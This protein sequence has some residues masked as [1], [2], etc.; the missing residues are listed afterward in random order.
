MAS[1]KRKSRNGLLLFILGPT[2]GFALYLTLFAQPTYETEAKLIVRESQGGGGGA[3]PG[4]AATLLGFGGRTSM[5]DVL[6]L[7]QYLHSA[8]FIEAAAAKFSLRDHFHSSPLDPF[9]R[10]E[11][12]AEAETF[13]K[14]FR[15]MVTV[16]IRAD[17][18]VLTVQVRAF[19]PQ[20]AQD[21]ARFI[22]ERSEET[23]NAL[24]QRMIAAQ[25]TLAQAELAKK[26]D[27]LKEVRAQLLEFQISHAMVDPVSETTVYF[28]NVAA[29][30]GRLMEKRTELRAKSHYLQEDAFELRRLR[31]EI[32]ALEEQR[33][34]ETRLLVSGGDA[35][36]ARTLQSYEG[37][38]LQ[39][40]FA[41][42]A[43]TAAVATAEQAT[44]EAT[45]QEK[46]LL[47]IA[48]PHAPEK[49]VFPR[50]LRGTATVLVLSCLG[51][52]ILRLIVATVRDHSI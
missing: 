47:V 31:Q 48:P 34:E 25:T 29:L 15:K 52:G 30:D 13:Y 14:F 37:L 50:P 17:S 18:G 33:T 26:L 44:M 28:G 43:Y 41:L 19:S 23:I 3:L 9:R 46:F 32:R 22:I 38:K 27:R 40:E 20:T 6:I 24:N 45:R 8:E 16:G 39:L 2:A 36:M 12:G 11:A 21:L 1:F 51:Y 49:P 4:F 5:E 10:L 42:T 35:S 7:E